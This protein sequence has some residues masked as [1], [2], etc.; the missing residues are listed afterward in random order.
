MV[1][2]L[3][4]SFHVSFH[5]VFVYAQCSYAV[6]SLPKGDPKGGIRERNMLKVT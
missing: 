6:H 1:C 4:V 3:C 2:L 5:V